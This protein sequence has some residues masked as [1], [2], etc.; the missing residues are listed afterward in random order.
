MLDSL[1]EIRLLAQGSLRYRRQILAMKHYFA[2]R[3]VTVLLLDDL[4]SEPQDRT[5]HSVVHGVMR[6]EEVA[7]DYGP[8]RRRLQVTKYR[9]RTFRAGHHDVA[10]RTG[11][12]AVY[13]RLIASEHRIPTDRNVVGSGVE[14]LDRLLGGGL[15][16]GSSTMLIGPAGTGKTMMSVQYVTAA[17]ARGERAAIF[18]FDEEIGLFFLRTRMLGYDLDTL[19]EAGRL[20]VEQVDAADLA[21]GEFAHCVRD[22]VGRGNVRTV[23]IDSL[24]GYRCAPCRRKSPS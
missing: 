6:L 13:P 20:H 9:G 15:L 10:L 18:L 19:R 5:V 23:V 22:I 7:S 17:I 8:G 14:G 2:P 16:Q 4:T 24:N 3:D 21:P 11:G 1:S 12:L